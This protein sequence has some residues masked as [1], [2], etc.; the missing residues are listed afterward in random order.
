MLLKRLQPGDWPVVDSAGSW[1]REA[2]ILADVVDATRQVAWTVAAVNSKHKPKQPKPYPRP[3]APQ[4]K[5][6]RSFYEAAMGV[7]KEQNRRRHGD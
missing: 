3:A 6:K 5:P 7:V 2:V 1:S 4:P